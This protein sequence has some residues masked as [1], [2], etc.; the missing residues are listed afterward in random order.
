[1]FLLG[2]LVFSAYAQQS[3]APHVMSPKRSRLFMASAL[4]AERGS[5]EIEERLYAELDRRFA[6]TS[7]PF[8][9]RTR[10]GRP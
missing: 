1:M 10:E 8:F 9:S 6:E 2:T 7:P 3:G 4:S 5:A